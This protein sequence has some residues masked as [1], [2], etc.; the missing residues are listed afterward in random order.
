MLVAAGIG[1]WLLPAW[2]LTGMALA[3]T[4]GL[5]TGA[6]LPVIQMWVEEGLNPFAAP[7]GRTIVV[8]SGIAAVGAALAHGANAMPDAA[9]LSAGLALMLGAT[10]AACRFALPP[11]D[12][13]ALGKTGRALRLI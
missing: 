9:A 5:C 3:V 13:E 7:S 4:A 8:T 11:G 1:W 10:W 12:R 6:V 2:G